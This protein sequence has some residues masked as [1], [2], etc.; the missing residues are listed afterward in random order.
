MGWQQF[1]KA[2]AD[3][4][5]SFVTTF[6]KGR[7]ERQAM[8]ETQ[9]QNERMNKLTWDTMG[10]RIQ[11]AQVQRGLLRQQTGTDLYNISREANRAA[12]QSIN[13]A[14]AAGIE[15]ASVDE[16]VNDIARQ[17]QT[18][19]AATRSAEYVQEVNL[20]TQITDIINSAVA[21]QRYSKKPTSTSAI[22]G[23]AIGTSAMT[24][25]SSLASSSFE[26][27]PTAG[28]NYTQTSSG[29]T[30]ALPKVDLSNNYSG[31]GAHSDADGRYVGYGAASNYSF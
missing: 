1:A 21:A 18:A 23:R 22:L 15:G 2:G 29:V 27:M 14:A 6:A 25:A 12:S 30:S 11:T 13:S 3:S 8:K 5:N 17:Q 9:A 19:Q 4:T 20:D 7:A 10:N 26:Y 28:T 16:A 31:F 24:F